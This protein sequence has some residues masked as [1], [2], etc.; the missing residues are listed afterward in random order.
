MRRQATVQTGDL[1]CVVIQHDLGDFTCVITGQILFDPVMTHCGQ[2]IERSA[3][4]RLKR[5]PCCNEPNIQFSEPSA[6]FKA[7]LQKTIHEYRLYKNVFFDIEG[8]KQVVA[9]SQLNTPL[10]ERFLTLLQNA[11]SHLNTR[12]EIRTET[13]VTHPVDLEIPQVTVVET[14]GKSPIEI[15]AEIRSGRDLLRRKLRITSTSSTTAATSGSEKYF[16]GNAEIF[17]ESLQIQVEGKS[18]RE[19]LDPTVELSVQEQ[20]VRERMI[21]EQT[22]AFSAFL[23]SKSRLF[24]GAR[25][26]LHPR[27]QC[28]NV[29]N[30]LQQ[31]V[32]GQRAQVR[33]TLDRIKRENPTLLKTVLTSV[34]T[35]PIIDYSGKIIEDMTLLQAAFAAGDVAIHPDLARTDPG[36]QG[37]CEI[38][39]SYFDEAEDQS[40]IA[41]QYA[42]ILKQSVQEN[43]SSV[44]IPP[45][46]DN[47]PRALH[48]IH[49]LAL[50]Q[51]TFDFNKIVAA[52][53]RAGSHTEQITAAL[54]KVGASFTESDAARAKPDDQLNLTESFN[55]F[56]EHFERHAL[57]KIAVNPYDLLNAFQIYDA[58]F[59]TWTWDQ[60]EL[61]VRQVIGFAQRY[62]SAA[63]ARVFA[64][65]LYSAVKDKEKV[66]D[67]F[68]FRYEPGYRLFPLS[69]DR[70]CFGL[71]FD[72]SVRTAGWGGGLCVRLCAAGVCLPDLEN[73]YRTKTSCQSELIPRP[74]VQSQSRDEP[75]CVI[76]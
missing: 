46:L 22:A 32:Y 12:E 66:P 5:C 44:Q 6:F 36:H 47:D 4:T 1:D 19:W 31:V 54:N 60:R 21:A 59:N 33:A 8:F 27:S 40:E 25:G 28:V 51:N 13:Q 55:R 56:R 10:G 71:G 48:D 43:Y 63:D 23:R 29:N 42:S 26:A 15:L 57:S 16:F 7:T 72:C 20:Q 75:C 38:I 50:E 62:L 9:K 70:S 37:M 64:Y 61:F 17:P 68:N 14:Q 76:Q 52:I 45:R 67:H 24:S 69:S 49:R 73:L 65:G 39:Q 18:I 41:E 35:T 58:Q 74:R 3:S 30:I 2:H 34:A 11:P 53:T